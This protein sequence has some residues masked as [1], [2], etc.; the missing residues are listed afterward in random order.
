MPP[1]QESDPL[2]LEELPIDE[3]QLSLWTHAGGCDVDATVWLS[4]SGNL[5]RVVRRSVFDNAT[6]QI[7]DDSSIQPGSAHLRLLRRIH[8][9]SVQPGFTCLARGQAKC[10]GL[11]TQSQR[12]ASCNGGFLLSRFSREA[13]KHQF[14]ASELRRER[15]KG[16]G[17][18]SG[19]SF[20]ATTRTQ[21]KTTFGAPSE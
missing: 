7:L 4:R 13:A 1:A 20:L 5:K 15:T 8:Y 18:D 17:V 21:R 11:R 16:R 14:C 12:Q 6:N 3:T 2:M 19:S 9:I 10:K